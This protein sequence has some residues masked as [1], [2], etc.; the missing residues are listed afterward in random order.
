MKPTWRAFSSMT[1]AVP[2][3]SA[4]TTPDRKEY[5]IDSTLD[6]YRHLAA[7][8][9]ARQGKNPAHALEIFAALIGE[10]LRRSDLS[11]FAFNPGEKDEAGKQVLQGGLHPMDEVQRKRALVVIAKIQCALDRGVQHFDGAGKRLSDVSS[12][13]AA[14]A[15]GG[16]IIKEPSNGEAIGSWIR[17]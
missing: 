9:K 12:I 17:Q 6:T 5:F 13:I 14:W 7:P 11:P 10:R 2:S 1:I 8:S 16:L 4:R 15:H 3:F